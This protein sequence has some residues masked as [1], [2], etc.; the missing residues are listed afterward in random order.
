ML[1]LKRN[2]RSGRLEVDLILK[3]NW[4]LVFCEV[5]TRNGVFEMKPENAIGVKKIDNLTRA[6]GLFTEEYK[7]EGPIRFDLISI[8]ILPHGHQL[9]YVPDAFFP[10]GS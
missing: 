5:K 4:H 3:D 2:W 6:A 9:F 1:L 10:L 8:S 7:H